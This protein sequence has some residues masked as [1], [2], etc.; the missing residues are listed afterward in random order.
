VRDFQASSSTQAYKH[1]IRSLKESGISS[2][3]IIHAYLRK[4]KESAHLL[5]RLANFSCKITCFLSTLKKPK[6]PSVTLVCWF[7]SCL[8]ERI[9]RA[10][11]QERQHQ[12]RRVSLI[13]GRK[14]LLFSEDRGKGKVGAGYEN[15]VSKA[16]SFCG[17]D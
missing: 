16:L 14:S 15:S 13:M 10:A 3:K 11:H 7:S 2:P 9:F 1:Q 8:T 4:I 5:H 12:I 17:A 6:L